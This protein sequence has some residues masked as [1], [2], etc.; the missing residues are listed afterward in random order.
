MIGRLLEISLSCDDV[1]KT[2]RTFQALGFR[3]IPTGDV[4]PHPY[5]VV[6]DG[7][8]NIGLH[9]Y[10]FDSPSLTFVQ[11]NLNQWSA[12]YR[13][14]GIELAFEKLSTESFNELGFIDPGG[15]M[16]AVLESRTFSPPPFVEQDISA[17]GRFVGFALPGG[18]ANESRAFWRKLG[19]D[20]NDYLPAAD[21][22]IRF[23]GD[24]TLICHFEADMQ[25][26]AVHV[27]RS[28]SADVRIANDESYARANLGGLEVHVRA[29]DS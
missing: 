1:L 18:L 11:S 8:I 27:A 23:D 28:G 17:L 20:D 16:S 29:L 13:I 6:S 4:W 26:L 3:D 19:L 22:R 21:A 15:Q 7:R 10:N 9:R 25:Y 12:A 14:Q 24:R 2:V 5:A